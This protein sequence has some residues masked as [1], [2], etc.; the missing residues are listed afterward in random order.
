MI[1]HVRVGLTLLAVTA[2]A[3]TFGVT[4]PNNASADQGGSGISWPQGQALP[5]FAEPKRLDVVDLPALDGDLK[6]MLGSLQGVVNRSEPRIYLIG[7]DATNGEGRLTWLKEL[8]VPYQIHKDPWAVVSKYRSSVRGI[9]ITDPNLIDTNNV[10]TTLAGLKNGIVAS[11]ALADRLKSKYGLP[12]L[13][14]LRGKFTS[15]LQAYQWQYEH[16]WPQTTHRML[17][18]LSPERDVPLP[19]GIPEGYTTIAKTTDH[20]HD[21]SNQQVYDFDLSDQLG[22]DAV[23]VRFDDAFTDDGWGPAVSQVTV[24]AGDQ[25][26][27]QFAPGTDAEEPFLFDHGNS[28]IS[29]GPPQHRYADGNRYFVYRFAPP[30]GTQQLTLSVEMWNEYTVSVTNQE[31]D[32]LYY[33]AYAYLRDYAVANKAMV[34]WLDPNIDAER[35]LFEQIMSETQAPTPYLGWFAQDVAGEFGGTQLA[36]EHGVYVLAADWFENMTV[37]S[38]SRAPVSDHQKAAPVPPLENKIYVT[39]TMSE[40]DNLQYNEHRLRQLWDDPGRGSV[41]INWST[42]PLL[43]DAAPNFLSHFQ[44]TATANDLLIAG[45]SGAG[46]IYPTPWPDDTFGKYTAQTSKYMKATGMDIVYVLNR[47]DGE[48][49]DLTPAEATAYVEQVKPR[50]MLLS[51]QGT[52]ETTM[53]NG[54]VPLSTVLGTGGVEDI[55]SSIA[56]AS[57]D[58]DGN[59]PLF[60]SIGVLAWNTTPTNLKTVADSLDAKYQIVR[61]DQYFEL[62]RKAAGS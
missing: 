53:L 33:E 12:V 39:F 27:A 45:P 36:S 11:P 7:P 1:R 50:G 23:W 47:V 25:V 37:H 48:N 3:A 18:G 34:F 2:M 60:L 58:W 43:L 22:G 10:A 55:K 54:K 26:I 31:P 51:W 28:Q 38:G 62:A 57:A 13:D 30:A 8:N 40:G 49:V 32:R 29:S 21:G 46:Y 19:P 35:E 6:L 56:E 44:R 14:D 42:S 61:G 52:T 16:L 41:P 9:I 20:V 4:A 5:H 24:K 59:S 17:V 15:R